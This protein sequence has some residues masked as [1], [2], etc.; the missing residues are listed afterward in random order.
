MYVFVH[1]H[2]EREKVRQNRIHLYTIWLTV[3]TY[4]AVDN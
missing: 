4:C 2:K 3:L 1:V